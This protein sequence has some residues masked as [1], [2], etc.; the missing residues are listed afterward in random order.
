MGNTDQDHFFSHLTKTLK[1]TNKP[2]KFEITFKRKI[3]LKSIKKKNREI[4]NLKKEKIAEFNKNPEIDGSYSLSARV[5]LDSKDKKTCEVR[6]ERAK[7]FMTSLIYLAKQTLMKTKGVNNLSKR[8]KKPTGR[9]EE[10]N[11][12]KK[13]KERIKKIKILNNKKKIEKNTKKEIAD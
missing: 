7:N 10:S 2:S 5:K 8:I 4:K 3:D 11:R 6:C 12:T 9:S 1:Q 13:R